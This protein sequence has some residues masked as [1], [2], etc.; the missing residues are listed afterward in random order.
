MNGNEKE[1]LIPGDIIELGFKT[2]T[3]VWLKSAQIAIIEWRLQGRKDFEI[4][5]KN[6]WAAKD[7]VIYKIR[8]RETVF[9]PSTGQKIA[10]LICSV[11]PL[12]FVFFHY[13][14]ISTAAKKIPK[15][16]KSVAET[17]KKVG[18]IMI[19]TGKIAL[20]GV[21]IIAGLYVAAKAKPF[22]K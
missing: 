20:V 17:T 16:V 13:E 14:K 9:G 11:S 4:I 2:K 19:S 21:L 12:A 3:G 6:Y 15:A 8:I 5:G 22:F 10:T 18:E 7:Q 1:S